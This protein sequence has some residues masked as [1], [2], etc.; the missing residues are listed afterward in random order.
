MLFD[1]LEDLF[2]AKLISQYIKS[3]NLFIYVYPATISMASAHGETI[4]NLKTIP[5]ERVLRI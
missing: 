2:N 4:R 1:I 5:V 3:D